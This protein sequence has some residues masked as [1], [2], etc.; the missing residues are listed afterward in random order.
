MKT[1][2]R[3]LPRFKA[4]LGQ[5]S[6]IRDH[7][8]ETAEALGVEASVLD[9]LRL[10]V[11]EAVTNIIV[12]G[13]DGGTGDIAVELSADGDDFVVLLR[14]E[15]PVF[16]PTAAS[17]D[18]ISPDAERTTPGGFGLFLMRQEMDEIS[19]R[20]LDPGNELRMVKRNV[21]SVK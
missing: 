1:S 3:Q 13:Y 6:H 7:V 15:A 12:H 5:L 9:G 8:T 14:D 16:D 4:E 11:D 17:P 19:H 18:E 21:I 20:P 10:A 2:T